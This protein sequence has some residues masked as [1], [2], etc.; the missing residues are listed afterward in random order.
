VRVRRTYP[1]RKEEKMKTP[2][3]HNTPKAFV[4][5][6]IFL[7]VVVFV[8][9]IVA[10]NPGL[11]PISDSAAAYV[12]FSD[13]P[14][15]TPIRHGFDAWQA[16]GWTGGS[17]CMQL[18]RAGAYLEATV[19]VPEHVSTAR[20]TIT[21]R[22]GTAP[23]CANGGFAPIT[24]TVNGIAVS[25][26]FA[27]PAL[28]ARADGFTTDRWDLAAWLVSGR[29]RIR[30]TAGAL[31]SLY[32]I[33]RLELA[34]TTDRNRLIEAHQMTRGIANDRPTDHATVFAPNDRWAVCWTE[35][36]SEARG[37]RIEFRF[38]DPS[39][40]LYFKTDRTADR[41]NWGYINVDGWRAAS[42]E[43]PW[44]VDVFVAGEF[45]LSV[46][47]RIG[48]AWSGRT[49]RVTGVNFPS[50][51]RANGERASGYVSF[52]D[53]DGDITWVTFEAVDGFF[54]DFEFDPNVGGRADGR[55]SFYV[56]THLTQRVRLKIILY[57]RCG[58]ESEPYYLAF[59]AN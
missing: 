39:G 24:L 14:N 21:H 7:G 38:Y 3:L 35:V 49:P 28:G 56:Y 32:E 18:V 15:G 20:L 34:T 5:A 41:Y 11:A 13:L 52:H 2:G 4:W 59:H 29:N 19:E 36:A 45:Q 40:S 6:T 58:N 55:F 25:H 44:R 9:M 27:P 43:G 22:S 47:F 51:I 8:T 17:R 30:I 12:D 23:G 53:P 26:G 48:S 33:Q 37:R 10:A 57:D 1:R 31:C 50:V 42:L 46:P 16:Q 54:S